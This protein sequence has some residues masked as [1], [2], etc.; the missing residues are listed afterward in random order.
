MEQLTSTFIDEDSIIINSDYIP[1]GTIIQCHPESNVLPDTNI[2]VKCDGVADLGTNF[3]IP[4]NKVPNLSDERF[5]M[6]LA[7]TTTTASSDGSNVMINH[8]HSTN[9]TDLNLSCNCTTSGSVDSLGTSNVSLAS[10]ATNTTGVHCH[11]IGSGF[12]FLKA[13]PAEASH[14]HPSASG[15]NDGMIFLNLN[16][17]H[18]VSG[19][20]NIAHSHTYNNSVITCTVITGSIGDGANDVSSN[21]TENRPQYFTVHYYMRI[22]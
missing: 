16:H 22:Q 3:N 14:S 10:G 9:S 15:N 1:I 7:H 5:L 2:W 8:K 20:T 17:P 21:T 12:V 6:G 4:T 11:T 19:T 18:T 13:T